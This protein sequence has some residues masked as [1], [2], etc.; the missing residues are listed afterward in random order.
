LGREEEGPL[1][2]ETTPPGSLPPE[3]EI[4][5]PQ[6]RI[7]GFWPTV[8]LGAAILAVYVIAQTIVAVIFGIIYT[9]G[10]L[11][12][13][14]DLD[15][16]ATVKGLT[17]NGLLVTLAT[18]V[19]AIAGFAAVVFF[20]RI[21][22]GISLREYLSLKPVSIRIIL[23]VLVVLAALL[24][25]SSGLDRFSGNSRNT[26][27]MVDIYRTAGWTPLLWLA[28]VV[29]APVFEESFFR[30][31]LFAGLSRS[32]I[33]PAGAIILTALVFAALHGLQ[34]D[35]YGVTT[36]FIMGLFLGIARWKTGSLWSTILL[37]AC[38]NLAGMIG[39][40]LYLGGS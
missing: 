35:I 7:W 3:I 10:K 16:M 14:P 40:A 22:R 1:Q 30:G 19:S 24:A 25:L 26:N 18:F 8:G 6:N 23:V 9:L 37:H 21:R 36:V 13:N 33:G 32:L 27:F 11:S 5:E 20:I 2:V 28:T 39:T 15:I 31:F 29:F 4:E 38:W 17:S 34:Y 12:A